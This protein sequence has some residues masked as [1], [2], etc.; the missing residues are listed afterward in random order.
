MRNPFQL[1]QQNI[2]NTNWT[3]PIPQ[4][5]KPRKLFQ[6]DSP[7]EPWPENLRQE[8]LSVYSEQWLKGYRS[9]WECPDNTTSYAGDW[10]D[11]WNQMDYNLEIGFIR[12]RP[13][14]KCIDEEGHISKGW[15]NNPEAKE[16]VQ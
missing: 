3:P 9:R 11:G 5:E 6:G 10:N 16:V 1:A 12:Q 15:I 14:I 13:M 8:S 7:Y 4:Q 2:Q